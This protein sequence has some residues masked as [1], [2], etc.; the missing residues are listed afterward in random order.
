[1]TPVV[2]VPVLSKATVPH[3]RTA[4]KTFALLTKMSLQRKCCCRIHNHRFPGSSVIHSILHPYKAIGTST[5]TVYM[6]HREDGCPCVQHTA[7]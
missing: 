6:T 3:V 7:Y 5:V 4:S 1:M 2:S